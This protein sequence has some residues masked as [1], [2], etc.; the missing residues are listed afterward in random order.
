MPV[1]DHIFSVV[2]SRSKQVNREP[3]VRATL[4]VRWFENLADAEEHFK[5][6]NLKTPVF[7]QSEGGADR[8]IMHTSETKQLFQFGLNEKAKQLALKNPRHNADTLACELDL[9]PTAGA[10][11]D[12][13]PKK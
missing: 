1:L 12:Q 11:F 4:E 8:G 2:H 6:V 5:K 13:K 10:L 9:N 3:E 7:T